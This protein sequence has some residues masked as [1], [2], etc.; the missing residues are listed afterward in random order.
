[1]IR[2]HTWTDDEKW[3]LTKPITAEE[4]WQ[5]LDKEVDLDSSPG[6]DGLTYRCLKHFMYN[7]SFEEIYIT[8]LNY[9]RDLG[10]YVCVGNNG[11][12]VIKNKKKVNQ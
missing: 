1:M 9:T 11:I 12:M 8:F 6:E 3:E 2:N 5:I 10:N 4:I 7:K